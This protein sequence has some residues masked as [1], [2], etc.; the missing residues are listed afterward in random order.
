YQH[1]LPQLETN[2]PLQTLYA[3]DRECQAA[4]PMIRLYRE[5]FRTQDPQKKWFMTQGLSDV[6]QFKAWITSKIAA[7]GSPSNPNEKPS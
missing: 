6:T 2:M 7:E 4:A 1:I 3:N 5:A